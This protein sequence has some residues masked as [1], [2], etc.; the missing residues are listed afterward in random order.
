MTLRIP[1]LGALG[2]I[3]ALAAAAALFL[4]FMSRFGGPSVRLSQPYEMSALIPDTEGLAARSGDGGR[5]A[6][7]D[8][9]SLLDDDIPPSPR[10]PES[11]A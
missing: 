11:G 2:L 3:L 7:T 10:A 5:L 8:L 9:Q 4:F 6:Y 1:K